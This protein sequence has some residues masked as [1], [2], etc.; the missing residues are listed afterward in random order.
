[1]S[2]VHALY[3][4]LKIFFYNSYYGGSSLWWF[5]FDWTSHELL[6]D[7]ECD[8]ME[9]GE[10]LNAG[11]GDNSDTVSIL[12]IARNLFLDP[13]TSWKRHITISQD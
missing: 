7:P 4:N 6:A 3:K 12:A 2:L 8:D 1:M 10:R 9:M 5:S 11:D 13:L